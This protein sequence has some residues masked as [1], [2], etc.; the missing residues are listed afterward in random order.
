M[1]RDVSLQQ[2]IVNRVGIKTL[3]LFSK[4]TL[5]SNNTCAIIA[6]YDFWLNSSRSETPEVADELFRY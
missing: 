5:C 4:N 2:L 3:R 1:V 6:V